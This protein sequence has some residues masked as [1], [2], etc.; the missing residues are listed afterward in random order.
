MKMKDTGPAM[1]KLHISTLCGP[2]LFSLIFFSCA[3]AEQQ[4]SDID[5]DVTLHCSADQCYIDG[6]CVA[7][8]TDSFGHYCLYCDPERNPNGWSRYQKHHMRICRPSRGECDPVEFCEGETDDCP[9]DTHATDDTPCG[10]FNLCLDQ[11]TC[12]QGHCLPTLPPALKCAERMRCDQG[13]QSCVCKD[14]FT[15]ENCEE[16]AE[17]LHGEQCDLCD[18]PAYTG[19]SCDIC[20]PGYY[21]HADQRGCIPC[22]VNCLHGVPSCAGGDDPPCTCDHGWTGIICDRCADNF[23]G[24]NCD[25]CKKGYAGLHCERCD[26]YFTG[27][28]C[29][30]CIQYHTGEDCRECETNRTG[31]GCYHCIPGYTGENCDR[32]APGFTGDTCDQ[33]KPGH[34]GAHCIPAPDCVHGNVQGTVC[35][36]EEGWFGS[37]CDHDTLILPACLPT[38]K[39]C[40]RD[41]ECCAGAYCRDAIRDDPGTCASGG[42]R[43]LLRGTLYGFSPC[44]NYV[45]IKY[46][47]NQKPAA[48]AFLDKGDLDSRHVITLPPDIYDWD[49]NLAEDLLLLGGR[50]SLPWLKQIS[51]GDTI[52]SLDTPIP[53]SG[54]SP[55][56]RYLLPWTGTYAQPQNWV[57]YDLYTGEFQ[58][59]PEYES[60]VPQTPSFDYGCMFYYY[61]DNDLIMS[62]DDSRF[63]FAN[64]LMLYSGTPIDDWSYDCYYSDYP[65]TVTLQVSLTD[66][67]QW[68]CTGGNWQQYT[69]MFYNRRGD[70]IAMTTDSGREIILLNNDCSL[71]ARYPGRSASFGPDGEIAILTNDGL[72]SIY[73]PGENTPYTQYYVADRYHATNIAL[74]PD[75]TLLAVQRSDGILVC[76]ASTGQQLVFRQWD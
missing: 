50:D 39:A 53:V 64:L 19:V 66:D 23:I 13:S 65:E 62:P 47:D 43:M 6:R 61:R 12:Q 41:I 68:Q 54:I 2:L 75:G 40:Y 59:L 32:C 30:E 48:L 22:P 20:S 38:G 71:H 5:G 73:V 25:Q 27:P 8:G 60:Y 18:D 15:G 17:G 63:V 14:N 28:D 16:C 7:A 52:L 44:G 45:V 58:A 72:I 33:C 34:E 67:L 42:S 46:Q 9:V 29:G 11:N 10:S 70:L 76:D 51:T 31:P 26:Y 1:V 55:T 35:V 4:P 24:D 3:P 74:S 57:W 56:G 69:G 36:C 37:R 49:V 21:Y